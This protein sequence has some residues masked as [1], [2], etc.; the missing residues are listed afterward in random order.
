VALLQL[1]LEGAHFARCM[2]LVVIDEAGNARMRPDRT[3]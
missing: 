1:D 3:P 2:V